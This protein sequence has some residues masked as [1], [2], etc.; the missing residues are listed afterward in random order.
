[1]CCNQIHL[2]HQMLTHRQ[3]AEI[4]QWGSFL[5]SAATKSCLSQIQTLCKS[6]GVFSINFSRSW[7]GSRE[8]S[9]PGDF[10][11]VPAEILQK[12]GGGAGDFHLYCFLFV[13]FALLSGQ[14]WSREVLFQFA[15]LL[16]LAQQENPGP[17]EIRGSFAIYSNLHL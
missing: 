16:S 2:Y 1:M 10:F 5:Q 6:I 15:E 17:D 8:L 13:C 7:V 12:G 4:A 11:W 14:F 9:D 3:M